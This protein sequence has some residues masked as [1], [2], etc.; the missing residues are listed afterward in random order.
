MD[1]EGHGIDLEPTLFAL[2]R[3]LQP[4]LVPTEGVGQQTHLGVRPRTLTGGLQQFGQVVR[5]AGLLKSAALAA[6]GG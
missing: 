5:L 4:G 3:P 2:A 6:G 1:V